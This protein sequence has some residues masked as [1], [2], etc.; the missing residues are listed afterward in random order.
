MSDGYSSRA[1]ACPFFK[2]A[3]RGLFVVCEGGSMAL[4]RRRDREEFVRDYCCSVSGWRRI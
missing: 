3:K 1:W 2:R 4:P